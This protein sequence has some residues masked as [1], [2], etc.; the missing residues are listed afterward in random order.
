MNKFFTLLAAAG[1]AMSANATVLWEGEFVMDGSA[2]F[3]EC[4]CEGT[5]WASKVAPALAKAT[6]KSKLVFTYSEVSTPP[7]PKWN[8][9]AK[10]RKAKGEVIP[11]YSPA[12]TSPSGKVNS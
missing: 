12:R 1:L 7:W 5:D 4:F 3:N 2:E 9:S 8:S 6:D 10:G 11:P